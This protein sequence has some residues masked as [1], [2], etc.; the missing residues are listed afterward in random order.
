MRHDRLGRSIFLL[1]AAF[2][3]FV[4]AFAYGY[5][6]ATSKA[7]PHRLIAQALTDVDAVLDLVRANAH[8]IRSS[9]DRGGVTVHV[10]GLTQPGLT[11]VTAYDGR[12]FRP[13]VIDI[14]GKVLH[15]WDT[16]YGALFHGETE[17]DLVSE[18]RRHLHGAYLYADGSVL[19]SYEYRG[20][21]KLDRCSR[22]VWR[23][24]R[25]TH[26]A[27][28]MLPDGSFWVPATG[29]KRER[30]Y[31]AENHR[32]EVI[33]HVSGDGKVLEEINIIDAIQKGGYQSILLQGQP[34]K[35]ENDS[36]DPIHLNDVEIV[37]AAFAD[38]IP[39]IEPGDFLI[40]LRGPDALAVISHRSKAVVWSMIGPFLR[41]H[42]PDIMDDGTL[43]VF[44]N[45]A[46]MAQRTPVR[47]L[48]D[49][50]VWGYSRLLRLDPATQ[51]VLWSFAGSASFPFYSSIQGKQQI[52]HNGD[53]L[54][55][56]PEGGRAFE[57]A[58]SRGNEI[59]WEYVNK[60]DGKG[61]GILGRVTEATRYDY[62]G[63]QF[64][65]KPCP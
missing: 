26:H 48:E 51:Q 46:E 11:F 39:Q 25:G 44:D 63:S 37:T 17:P 5:F 36:E 64:L 62:D 32:E 43:L 34:S 23:L 14:D 53:I 24:R 38:R 47:W 49:P 18:S 55:S 56:D 29:K 16:R 27:V 52:L 33:L 61:E 30:P 41:Q 12:Y 10:Q 59:V 31:L 22:A 6:V 2:L 35:P 19:V 21:A 58:P 13:F 54:V 15:K 28:L 40:S 60:L 7:Y 8:E 20:L 9:R 65:N 1:S 42:D 4:G 57:I 50:Q 3:L 45:R